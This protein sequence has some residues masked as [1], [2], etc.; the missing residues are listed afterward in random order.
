MSKEKNISIK[1]SLSQEEVLILACF[2]QGKRESVPKELISKLSTENKKE[3]KRLKT[4]YKTSPVIENLKQDMKNL[5]YKFEED[6]IT[7]EKNKELFMVALGSEI[8]NIR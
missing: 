7:A 3:F 2:L 1:L 5:S 8:N 6:I 4:F